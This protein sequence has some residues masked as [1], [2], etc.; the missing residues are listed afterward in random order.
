[1][2]WNNPPAQINGKTVSNPLVQSGEL[3]YYVHRKSPGRPPVT[4]R[5]SS[6]SGRIVLQD[7][8]SGMSIL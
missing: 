7:V 8:Q 5:S 1:M 6:S 2:H 3:Q 4:F